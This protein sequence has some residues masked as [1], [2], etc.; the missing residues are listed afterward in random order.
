MIF[1]IDRAFEYR[2]FVVLVVILAKIFLLY[3][4]HLLNLQIT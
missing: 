2:A 1:D 3:H 4:N